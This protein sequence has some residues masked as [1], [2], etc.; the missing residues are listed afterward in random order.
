MNEDWIS[1]YYVK[2]CVN[3]THLGAFLELIDLDLNIEI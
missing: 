3:H 2:L 1:D